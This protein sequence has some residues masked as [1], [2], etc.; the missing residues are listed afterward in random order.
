[1]SYRQTVPLP[2]FLAIR[3]LRSYTH[4][5]AGNDTGGSNRSW[6]FEARRSAASTMLFSFAFC[7]M[8]DFTLSVACHSTLLFLAS[9]TVIVISSGEMLF[10]LEF[11]CSGFPDSGDTLAELD[12]CTLESPEVMISTIMSALSGVSTSVK[13]IQPSIVDLITS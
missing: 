4:H 11:D 5:R 1:M 6:N 9:K 10:R 13:R 2:Y 12:T 8:A 7:F 3:R